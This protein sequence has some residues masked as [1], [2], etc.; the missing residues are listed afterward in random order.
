MAASVHGTI[1]SE[2]E[3]VS[4]GGIEPRPCLHVHRTA[5][6]PTRLRSKA[7]VD[8]LKIVDCFRR[9]LRATRPAELV[10]VIHPIDPYGVTTW[11]YAA[12]AESERASP[13]CKRVLRQYRVGGR[14][15]R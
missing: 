5:R 3:S 10:V 6:R 13:L 8:D 15:L 11:P 14:G 1:L 12:E 4:M 7:V 2:D 9:K